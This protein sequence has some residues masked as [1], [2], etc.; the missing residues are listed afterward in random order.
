MLSNIKYKWRHYRRE[1]KRQKNWFGRSRKLLLWSFRILL[2]MLIVDAF[3]LV[4]IWPDWTNFKKGTIQKSNFI[5]NYQSQHS[6]L[7]SLKWNPVRLRDIP[8]RLRHAVIVAEDARF[9]SHNG[10]DIFAFQEAMQHNLEKKRFK[11]GGSTISQQTVKNMF[12]SASRNPLRKWHELAFTIGMEFNVSKDRIMETY[13][14]VAEFGKGIYGV[15]A[16]SRAYWNI[17]VSRISVQQAIELAAT[18]PSPVKHN[19]ATRT[20]TFIRRVKKIRAYIY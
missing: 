7:P 17:P 4:H 12:F 9:Y 15:E 11:Y 18:L 2:I 13:L 16:A 19:P 14:N 1:N 10:F 3:Y 20:H 8:H 6:N 5:K